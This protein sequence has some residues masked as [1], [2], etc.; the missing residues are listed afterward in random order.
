[1]IHNTR[2][3]RVN[4]KKTYRSSKPGGENPHQEA[5]DNADD[6]H[7]EVGGRQVAQE[8]VSARAH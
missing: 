8:D 5:G 2:V 3:I 6:P 4:Q 1:M 7:T